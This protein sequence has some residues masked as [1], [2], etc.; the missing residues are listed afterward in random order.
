MHQF[1]GK[2]LPLTNSYIFV[3]G[4]LVGLTALAGTFRRGLLHLAP[5]WHSG[6]FSA[7]Y[8]KCGSSVIAMAAHSGDSIHTV[9]FSRL[10]AASRTATAPS[11]RLGWRTTWR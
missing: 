6:T 3:P 9:I 7:I 1:Y 5:R 4:A 10:P 8:C 11:P 2:F